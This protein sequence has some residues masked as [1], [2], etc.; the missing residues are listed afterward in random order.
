MT[1]PSIGRV[2]LKG[3]DISSFKGVQLADYRGQEIGYLFEKF[4]RAFGILI[5]RMR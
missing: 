2:L 4:E 5:G 3:K 1:K